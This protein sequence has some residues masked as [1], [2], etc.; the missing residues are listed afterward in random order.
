M[1]LQNYEQCNVMA[2]VFGKTIENLRK[3][4]DTKLVKTDGSENEKLRKIKAK[5][6]FNIRVK[7]FQ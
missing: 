7:V 6:N 4:V 1:R 5:P 2:Y 3:R